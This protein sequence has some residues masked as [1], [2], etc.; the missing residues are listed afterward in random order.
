MRPAGRAPL[1][2]LLALGAL[3]PSSASRVRPSRAVPPASRLLAV[4]S[5]IDQGRVGGVHQRHSEGHTTQTCPAVRLAFPLAAA[6]LATA[7]G[8]VL[9]FRH[10]RASEAAEAARTCVLLPQFV[11]IM[12]S[13]IVVLDSYM[14]AEAAHMGPGESGQLVGLNWLG[15]GLGFVSMWAALR[16]RPALWKEQPRAI[17]VGGLCLNALGVLLYL[18]G[19]RAI[20]SGAAGEAAAVFVKGARFLGGIGQGVVAQLMVVTVQSLTPSADMGVQMTRVFFVNTVGIGSGPVIAA[21][22][23]ALTFCPPE[24][25]SFV[26]APAVQLIV[27]L[28]ALLA[29]VALFPDISSEALPDQPGGEAPKPGAEEGEDLRRRRLLI[30]CCAVIFLLRNLVVSGVEVGTALLLERDFGFDRRLVGFLVGATFFVAF[31]VRSAHQRL[32]ERL[33]LLGQFRLFAGLAALGCLL[34]LRPVSLV[35]PH[36]VALL[37]ADSVIF[38]CAFL[39]DGLSYGALMQNVFPEGS[40]LDKNHSALWCNLLGFGAGRLGG[41]WMARW[42]LEAL[43]SAGQDRYALWQLL[44]CVAALAI[45]ESGVKPGLKA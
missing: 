14:L 38:P 20:E 5:A 17:C 29:V 39:A 37:L 6:A 42:H 8:L 44:A 24:Q 25:A 15:A 19:A 43:G 30:M 23:H 13:T 31:P 36:G 3:L 32:R 33:S 1:R 34:L 45:F 9:V 12:G 10:V 18:L 2:A 22:A 21:G 27:S 26:S 35:L 16:Q 40:L 4:P 28:G 7:A 41:P 11:L